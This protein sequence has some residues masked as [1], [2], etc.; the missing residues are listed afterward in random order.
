M[1]VVGVKYQKT[2]PFYL[3]PTWRAL[4]IRVLKRDNFRCVVCGA[5]VSAV[6]SARVDHIKPRSTHPQLSLDYWNL[7]TL[8][9][10]HDSQAHRER[11]R[12][13]GGER[14]ERFVVPGSDG[15][16]WPIGRR[17]G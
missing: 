10:L 1:A 7:R 13:G 14:I 5:D 6:G 4:R 11:Q 17:N 9:T 15:D 2:D 8:C 3:T 16:G 12:G